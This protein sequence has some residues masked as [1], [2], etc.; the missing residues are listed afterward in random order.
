MLR[1]DLRQLVREP[2]EDKDPELEPEE[3]DEDAEPLEEDDGDGRGE[4][5]AYDEEENED[6]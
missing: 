5:I 1:H 2:K 3:T 4:V 6:E